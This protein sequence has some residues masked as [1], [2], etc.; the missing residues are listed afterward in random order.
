MFF[1]GCLIIYFEC[2]RGVIQKQILPHSSSS[3][4]ENYLRTLVFLSHALYLASHEKS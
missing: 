3:L 1:R 4:E 2:M